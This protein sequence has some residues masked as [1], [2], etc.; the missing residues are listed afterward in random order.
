MSLEFLHFPFAH[1]AWAQKL[2]RRNNVEGIF[3][4]ISFPPSSLSQSRYG[5]WF[6]AKP[7]WNGKRVWFQRFFNAYL[8]GG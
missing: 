5:L 4:S 2:Q 3:S 7:P 6:V 1:Q 8:H